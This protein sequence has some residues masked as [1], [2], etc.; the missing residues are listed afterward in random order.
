MKKITVMGGGGTGIMMAADLSMKGHEVTLFEIP[1]CADKIREI[2]ERGYVDIVGNAVNGR[3]FIA[4]ITTDIEEAMKDPEYILAGVI[5]QRQE[6]LID[7]MLPYLQDGQTVCFS[8]GNCAS[9]ILKN[10]LQNS[11]VLVGEMQGNI[12]PCR[13]L[14]DGKIISAFSYKEK[15]MAAFPAEDNEKYIMSMNQIYPCHAV[16]NVFEATLNS[17]NISIHLAGSLLG[18]AKMETTEDFRLYRDGLSPS[19]A[20]LIEAVEDE[21]ALVMEKMGYHMER[22]AG[23]IQALLEYEKHPELE[24]FRSLEGPSE[25]SHRYIIEDAYAG[26][27]LLLSLAKEYG[28]E[29]P[30]CEGL[31]A[32]ASALNKTQF[33]KTGRTVSY[34]GLSGLSPGEVNQYLETGEKEQHGKSI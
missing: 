2:K 19:V 1:G 5:A 23:Q 15:G 22:A 30:L 10:R 33:Y 28:I 21:K 11:N 3:A 26:N 34:F 17:P 24:V 7:L 8:A 13:M 31:L 14:S 18:T 4:H 25:I 9:I 29:A 6:E 27:S 16:K 32:I 12:Y 20:S